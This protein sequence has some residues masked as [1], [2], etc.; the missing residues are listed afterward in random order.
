[1]TETEFYYLIMCLGAF[2]AFALTLAYSTWSW[3]RHGAKS[4][5]RS[6][7]ASHSGAK[8]PA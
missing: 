7:S 8:L 6:G 2:L 1:M 3:G 5:V 4:E